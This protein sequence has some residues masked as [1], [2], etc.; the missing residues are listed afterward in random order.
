MF[1]V[2]RIL[3]ILPENSFS[4]LAKDASDIAESLPGS[5]PDTCMSVC[6]PCAHEISPI[7]S[8]AVVVLFMVDNFTKAFPCGQTRLSRNFSQ[9]DM[10]SRIYTEKHDHLSPLASWMCRRHS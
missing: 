8:K 5:Q 7:A 2:A 3:L 9:Q 6:A 10:Y 1:G 4:I